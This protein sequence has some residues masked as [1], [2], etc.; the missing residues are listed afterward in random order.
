MKT[1]IDP[2][3]PIPTLSSG[4]MPAPPAPRYETAFAHG[5]RNYTTLDA[6]IARARA[7]YDR[8][9]ARITDTLAAD[10]REWPDAALDAFVA[11]EARV[12]AVTRLASEAK[13]MGKLPRGDQFLV[14]DRDRDGR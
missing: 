8:E 12:N 2:V 5:G 4:I 1:V 13:R 14:L 3:T 7:D 11:A 6:R 10:P 9:L